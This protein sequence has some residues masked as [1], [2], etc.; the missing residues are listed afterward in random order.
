MVSFYNSFGFLIAFM[1]LL[2]I[3]QMLFGPKFSEMF[4][5]LVLASMVI[6]NHE[7]VIYL[8]RDMSNA[9]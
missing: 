7:K 3:F 5:L 6:V 9:E 8:M 2:L 4:M 1:V